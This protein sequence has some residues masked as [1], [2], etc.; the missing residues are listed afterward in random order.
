VYGI[1]FNPAYDSFF[2]FL[3]WPIPDEM[4]EFLDRS[5]MAAGIMPFTVEFPML[6]PSMVIY[7][8]YSMD[9]R[10]SCAGVELLWSDDQVEFMFQADYQPY[11]IRVLPANGVLAPAS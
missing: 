7:G 1:P 3:Q 4:A 8:S 6:T 9:I 10:V 5:G 2:D 11:P